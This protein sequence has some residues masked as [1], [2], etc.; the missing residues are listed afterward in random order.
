M[1]EYAAPHHHHIATMLYFNDGERD[2]SDQLAYASFT[3]GQFALV[4]TDV[5]FTADRCSA[6]WRKPVMMLHD[7]NIYYQMHIDDLPMCIL[8]H[9]SGHIERPIPVAAGETWRTWPA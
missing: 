2:I 5:Q 9:A 3:P 6:C 1:L 4:L 8:C 7:G